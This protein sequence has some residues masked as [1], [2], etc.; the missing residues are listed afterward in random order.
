MSDLVALII[1][2]PRMS[3]SGAVRACVQGAQPQCWEGM[4]ECAGYRTTQGLCQ[5]ARWV[6]VGSAMLPVNTEAALWVAG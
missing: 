1:A 4:R 2:G 6:S 3:W 5:P